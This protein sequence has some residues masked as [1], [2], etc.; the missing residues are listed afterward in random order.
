[1]KVGWLKPLDE[2]RNLTICITESQI[3][4]NHENISYCIKPSSQVCY[5]VNCAYHKKVM[6]SSS[7]KLISF[8]QVQG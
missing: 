4:H 6:I 5:E 1:M 7:F 2:E 3:K 8:Y